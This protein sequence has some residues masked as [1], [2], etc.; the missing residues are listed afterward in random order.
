LAIG[1][2]DDHATTLNRNGT[3]ALSLD[4]DAQGADLFGLALGA[5]THIRNVRSPQFGDWAANRD[6]VDTSVAGLTFPPSLQTINPT[7]SG[8]FLGTITY[9]KDACGIVHLEGWASHVAGS[10]VYVVQLPVGFRPANDAHFAVN[11][12]N[13]TVTTD[14]WVSVSALGILT[15]F[16]TPV[17]FRAA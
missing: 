7:N 6:Y 2:T 8:E 15:W 16:L 4:S 14:G 11:V 17:A 10:S 3:V 5:S 12:G 1:A 9:W 13:V